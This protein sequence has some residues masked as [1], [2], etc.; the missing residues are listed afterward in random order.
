MLLPQRED[1]MSPTLVAIL[2]FPVL[3]WFPIRRWMNRWGAASSDVARVD[4]D[5]HRAGIRQRAGGGYL[6]M[7]R[8][9]RISTWRALQLRLAGSHLRLPRS[10]ERHAHSPRI[11]APRGW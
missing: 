6:A 7:A 1:V 10:A 9:D 3:Y 2:T 5:R 11:S 4:D 8:A